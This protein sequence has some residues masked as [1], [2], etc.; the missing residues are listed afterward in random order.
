[1]ALGE[2]QDINE[3]KFYSLLKVNRYLTLETQSVGKGREGSLSW[4]RGHRGGGKGDSFFAGCES[5]E[6]CE[7]FGE[8]WLLCGACS[9]ISRDLVRGE[10]I[11]GGLGGGRILASRGHVE[12]I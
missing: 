3:S 11:V 4:K 7:A 1:M 6:G 5:W 9:R 10:R 12:R 2:A 8:D